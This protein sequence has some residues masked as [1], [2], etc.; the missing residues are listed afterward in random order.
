MNLRR[1][2]LNSGLTQQ[3]LAEKAGVAYK[4][5]QDLE[6]GRLAG[7]TLA[8]VERLSDALGIDAWKLFHPGAIPEPTR[9]KARSP[10]THR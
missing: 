10:Q 1:A 5:Y 3:A 7:L 9:T 6:A 8:T 2:R 4:Y